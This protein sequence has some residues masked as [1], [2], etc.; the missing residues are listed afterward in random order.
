MSDGFADW[1]NLAVA[2]GKEIA[3]NA[4]AEDDFVTAAIEDIGRYQ[5]MMFD[6]APRFDKQPTPGLKTRVKFRFDIHRWYADPTLTLEEC[7]E[8]TEYDIWFTDDKVTQM[9]KI[10]GAGYDVSQTRQFVYRDRKH[11]AFVPSI[12]KL[13]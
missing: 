3:K 12:E 11:M 6:V 5:A 4:E 1:L 9:Q 7:A 2:S 10:L 13:N 8:E